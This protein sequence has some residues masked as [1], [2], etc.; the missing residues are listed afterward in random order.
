MQDKT[1]SRILIKAIVA[2]IIL[3]ALIAI[4]TVGIAEVWAKVESVPDVLIKP[5]I[6]KQ[7][8]VHTHTD[9]LAGTAD[10]VPH[11][12]GKVTL[13]WHDTVENAM[14]FTINQEN[15]YEEI[16][17]FIAEYSL[18]DNFELYMDRV[19]MFID[20]QFSRKPIVKDWYLIDRI[21][22]ENLGKLTSEQL[23]TRYELDGQ[24]PLVHK[25]T[26]P[27]N[28]ALSRLK[29]NVIYSYAPSEESQD[30]PV[31]INDTQTP[32]VLYTKHQG[33]DITYG[34]Y[35]CPTTM[36]SNARSEF[37]CAYYEEGD[38]YR[39][40]YTPSNNE[41]LCALAQENT[42]CVSELIE[43]EDPYIF[44]MYIY[45]DTDSPKELSI[46]KD[47]EED[48]A[49]IV[50]TMNLGDLIGCWGP[51]HTVTVKST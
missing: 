32:C 41:S 5:P 40:M 28:I 26:L 8:T 16:C 11:Y 2:I 47:W 37:A 45:N 44:F 12:T 24:Y 19:D 42:I 33:Q 9:L 14:W 34:A 23:T 29:P 20:V 31:I 39:I 3:S 1:K 15:L 25:G 4:M 51:S 13:R 18:P 49:P 21:T 17:M 36:I 30:Y 43:T 6:E 38:E 10:D 46:T 22:G 35:A 27:D 7:K 50:V 48:A